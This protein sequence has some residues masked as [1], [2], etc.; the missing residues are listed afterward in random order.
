MGFFDDDEFE[1]LLAESNKFK[2]QE[3]NEGNVQAIF[4]RC[5]AKPDSKKFS[6]ASLFPT[7]HG[8]EAGAE[9]QIQFDTAALVE[10]KRTIEY[11]FG[12]I[13][14]AHR[15]KRPNNLTLDDFNT[16]YLGNYW[17]DDEGILL[18]FLY[19]GVSP[20][21]LCISPF[22][23]KTDTAIMGS[24]GQVHPLP[25][26]PGVSGV[27]GGPQ[28]GV[29]RLTNSQ[30]NIAE[31]GMPHPEGIPVLSIFPNGFQFSLKSLL[32]LKRETGYPGQ[33]TRVS[34]HFPTRLSVPPCGRE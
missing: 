22:R 9:K 12:Q 1:T 23:E 25:E 27:V 24:C 28:G 15:T 10:N 30:P 7:T 19:L 34:P 29:G 8:Y 18:R 14:E 20:E 31:T 3:L 33:N 5:L 4:N 17:T 16:T 32:S 26:G 13:Q 21:T 11:L 2:P 6:Y